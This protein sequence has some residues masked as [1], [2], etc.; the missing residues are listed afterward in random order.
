[1]KTRIK[2]NRICIAHPDGVIKFFSIMILGIILMSCNGTKTDYD[3]NE[4]KTLVSIGEAIANPDSI[5]VEGI[6]YPIIK[7]DEYGFYPSLAINGDVRYY[8]VNKY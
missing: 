5:I 3:L 8:R 1:M 6:K 4:I 2:S 7:I